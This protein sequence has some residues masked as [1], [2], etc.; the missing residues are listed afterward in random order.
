FIRT[1]AH[2]QHQALPAMMVTYRLAGVDGEATEEV[3][4]TLADSDSAADQDPEVKFG[5]ARDIAE[6]SCGG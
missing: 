4:D 5:I 6:V 3:V 1:H 2:E